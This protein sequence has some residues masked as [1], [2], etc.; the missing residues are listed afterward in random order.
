MINGVRSADQYVYHYTSANTARNYILK[1][2]TLLLSPYAS[3]NDPK[4]TKDWQFGLGTWQN[5]DLGKYK[6]SALS[7]WLS[8]ELKRRTRLA[9]FSTDVPPLSGSHM[10]DILNRGYAKPRMWAQYAEKHTGIC[11]VFLKSS[12]LEVVKTHLKSLELVAGPVVYQNRLV[13]R[14][15]EPHEFMLNIDVYE[16]VGES[17]YAQAHAHQFMPELFFEKLQDWRDENE[18]RIVAFTDSPDNLLIPIRQCL[19]GVVHGDSTDPD[20]SEELMR[21]TF[22][23]NGVEHMGLNWKNSSPWYDYESFGW[24]PGKVTGP[25]RRARGAA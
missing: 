15:L 12:L 7:S 18:W 2:A 17:K 9:C 10:S 16:S 6:H 20:I 1:D 4:E 25:R 5:R 8:A 19:A 14:S 3:T 22:G 21:L 11:L 24:Q 23:W 13:V